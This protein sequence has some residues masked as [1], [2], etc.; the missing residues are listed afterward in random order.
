MNR[1]IINKIEQILR[2]NQ[3]K[4]AGVFGSYATEREGN[5]SDIDILVE[6]SEENSLL[7]YIGL[8]LQLEDALNKKVD[9]VE[10]RTIKKA[11]QESILRSEKRIYG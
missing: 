9:L 6:L 2:Q 10:Y 1:E 5:E 4:R 7:D 8:K 11:L 3:V